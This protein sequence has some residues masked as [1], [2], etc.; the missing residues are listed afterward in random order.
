MG[1]R[2][3][4]GG[5]RVQEEDEG[6]GAAGGYSSVSRSRERANHLPE[7]FTPVDTHIHT[8]ASGPPRVSTCAVQKGVRR[9]AAN[10]GLRA[11]L[12]TIGSPEAR[13][14]WINPW[15]G[16]VS[17]DRPTFE[18]RVQGTI[19]EIPCEQTCCGRKCLQNLCVPRNG[20]SVSRGVPP[21]KWGVNCG[22][23]RQAARKL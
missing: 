16:G 12:T 21:S 18:N 15:L 13:I 5:A 6:G 1:G 9:S 10:H 19:P 14:G 7:E 20:R 3:G 8:P 22:H 4:G 23:T 17:Q 11:I 2:A